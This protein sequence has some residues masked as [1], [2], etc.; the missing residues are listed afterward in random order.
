MPETISEERLRELEQLPVGTYYK[1]LLEKELGISLAEYRAL[2]AAYREREKLRQALE[3]VIFMLPK[4]YVLASS[5]VEPPIP[6]P[7][8]MTPKVEPP[9]ESK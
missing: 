9:M 4:I 7:L 5:A 2:I 1:D 6:T 3:R 8:F